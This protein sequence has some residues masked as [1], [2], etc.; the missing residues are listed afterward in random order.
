MAKKNKIPSMTAKERKMIDEATEL[1]GKILFVAFNKLNLED[2]IETEIVSDK[3]S[4]RFSLKFKK[5]PYET[6]EK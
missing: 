2:R 3:L 6:P 5:I 1:A 4:Q